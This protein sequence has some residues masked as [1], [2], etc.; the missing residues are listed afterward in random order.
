MLRSLFLFIDM[1]LE[2]EE[3]AL[4]HLLVTKIEL[5]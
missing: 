2:S 3:Y 5:W 4:K 1:S